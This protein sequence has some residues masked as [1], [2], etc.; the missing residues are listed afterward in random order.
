MVKSQFDLLVASLST[1]ER[2]EMLRKIEETFSLSPEP[3]TL[4]DSEEPEEDVDPIEYYYKSDFFTRIIVYIVSLFTGKDKGDVVLNT[5]LNR[6]KRKIGREYSRYFKPERKLGLPPFYG[7][8]V[9]MD[10]SFE[11]FREPLF[12]AM[13]EKEDFFVFMTNRVLGKKEEEIYRDTD[14]FYLEEEDRDLTVNQ[15]H[16]KIEE[17]YERIIKSLDDGKQ[18]KLLLYSAVIRELHNLAQ[19]DFSR[20]LRPFYTDG[21]GVTGFV[22]LDKVKQPLLV[23]NDIL[24]SFRSPPDIMLLE[25]L[26]L[27]EYRTDLTGE[28]GEGENLEDKLHRQIGAA[29]EGLNCIR[30]F[31][32]QIPLTDL[33]KVLTGNINY[34]PML[35][36]GGEGAL[37][38]YKIYLKS[39]IDERFRRYV[40]DKKKRDMVSTLGATWG[41]KY[42]E[43]IMGYRGTAFQLPQPF[44][45]ETSLS[46]ISVFFNKII[47]EK[48]YG[49]LNM[50]HI[51][52][53]FYRRDNRT[54]FSETY[55][56]LQ[57]LP[58][59]L[60]NFT[61]SF[62]LDGSF[63]TRFQ[64]AFRT[65]IDSKDGKEKLKT[66]RFMADR[67]ADLIIKEG[68]DIFSSLSSLLK[69]IIMGAGGAYDTLSNYSELGGTRNREFKNDLISLEF[70]V[71]SFHKTLIDIVSLEEKIA[72]GN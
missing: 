65:G 31:N 8:L 18:R 63:Y 38:H 58:S 15:I 44:T 55:E 59:K 54:E 2:K 69:G 37:R 57:A 9:N 29:V 10:K 3:M 45:Y 46:V 14:P 64:D 11:A 42:I 19:Y 13:K 43:P 17:N 23:L 21:E 49:P 34:Q 30:D 28:T 22:D 5:F 67:E 68:M 24:A 47:Q 16:R 72:R 70:L 32:K 66:V 62:L 6:L 20:V 41:I 53:D 7:L 39:N 33:L 4:P 61:V 40:N 1:D 51:N 60:R 35:S 71:S 26:F 48:Y 36:S 50:V 12:M 52:G 25:A 27:F 56:R